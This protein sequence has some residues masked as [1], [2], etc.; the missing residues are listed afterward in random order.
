MNFKTEADAKKLWCPF[1]REEGVNSGENPVAVNRW[2]RAGLHERSPC[3][4]SACMAWEW[5]PGAKVM[6]YDSKCK[7]F[8]TAMPG[9]KP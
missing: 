8:C 9:A 6:D 1:A 5:E 2:Y 3:I 7:G 4:A